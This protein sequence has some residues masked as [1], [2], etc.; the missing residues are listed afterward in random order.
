[1]VF[2]NSGPMKH[3]G[4]WVWD[5]GSGEKDQEKKTGREFILLTPPSDEAGSVITTVRGWC[6]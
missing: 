4:T 5:L 3:L 1:M 6:S 2:T